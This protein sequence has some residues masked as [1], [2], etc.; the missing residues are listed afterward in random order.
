[1]L[2]CSNFVRKNF[3]H[4]LVRG[5]SPRSAAPIEADVWDGITREGGVAVLRVLK[6]RTRNSGVEL[7]DGIGRAVHDGGA[8]VDNCVETRDGSNGFSATRLPEPCSTLYGMVL[9]RAGVRGKVGTIKEELG[10]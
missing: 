6:L 10:A 4:L 8:G 3:V 1:M 9:D 7:L 5:D 2:R